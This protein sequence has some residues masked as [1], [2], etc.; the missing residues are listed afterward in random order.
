MGHPREQISLV[1]WVKGSQQEACTASA[2][3]NSKHIDFTL[4][5]PEFYPCGVSYCSRIFTHTALTKG[6][7]CYHNLA[8]SCIPVKCKMWAAAECNTMKNT[9]TIAELPLPPH[10]E[11]LTLRRVARLHPK[12]HKTPTPPAASTPPPH[13][14]GTAEP[15]CSEC[16]CLWE[17]RGPRRFWSR[18]PIQ[19][20]RS[21]GSLSGGR[22]TGRSAA[23]PLV[24]TGWEKDI[25]G[26]M[27]KLVCSTIARHFITTSQKISKISSHLTNNYV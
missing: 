2:R 23:S 12:V 19:P 8:C 26:P 3:L 5:L 14:Q 24:C 10:Q 7:G 11:E 22:R 9:Y 13:P 21:A 15:V 1:I 25:K 17:T 20:S 27:E 4:F 16:G 6:D 18:G